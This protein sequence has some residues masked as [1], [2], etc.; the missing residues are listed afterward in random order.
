M[1]NLI[2][3]KG[4][5]LFMENIIKN[6]VSELLSNDNSG[7]GFEHISRVEELALKFAEKENANKEIVSITSLLHDVDD[8]KIFGIENSTN[9]T[10]AKKIMNL[11]NVD[12]SIQKKVIDNI[13]NMGYSKSLRGIRPTTL[14]GK[15][16]SDADMCD[17]IGA[18]G[19]IRSIVYAVRDK[20]NGVIFDKN[21]FP[22]DN[23]TYKEYN[24]HGST[25]DTDNAINHF[26]EKLLKLPSLMMTDSGREEASKRQKIMIDFLKQFF[27]E[28]DV[29]E[30]SK[31]LDDY[32]KKYP[33][34]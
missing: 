10:N 12:V 33:V 7:H 14:E 20:G 18:N 27:I 23:I 5:K 28:C 13:N 29:P 22:N 17:A 11:A 6:M 16:V 30:W 25:H 21:I 34:I 32:L 26:F 9:L 8:Y 31:Y 15:V 24:S 3:N 1:I 2:I 4:M 19:I